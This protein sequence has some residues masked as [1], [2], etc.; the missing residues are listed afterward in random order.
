LNFAMLGE[1]RAVATNGSGDSVT[2]S[3][4]IWFHTRCKVYSMLSGLRQRASNANKKI[5][6]KSAD[7]QRI[8]RN[9]G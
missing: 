8:L 1:N 9:N 6:T 7:G 4:E 3:L 5:R 2:S